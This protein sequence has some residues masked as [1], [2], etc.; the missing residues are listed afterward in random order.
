VSDA[1]RRSGAGHVRVA[2]AAGPRDGALLDVLVVT[3]DDLGRQEIIEAPR[4]G[5]ASDG[6]GLQLL[7]T[8]ARVP[9][10]DAP[11]THAIELP[12][13]DLSAW[14]ALGLAVPDDYLRCR[15]VRAALASMVTPHG[16]SVT[17]LHDWDGD[18]LHGLELRRAEPG[19]G[20]ERVVRAARATVTPAGPEL[21]LEEGTITTRGEERPFYGGSFRVALPGADFG[22]FLAA[23][24]P[25]AR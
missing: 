25:L 9:G 20:T 23:V 10:G 11:R 5:L 7:C 12:A 4:A 2:E 18:T 24:G 3:V 17:E 15:A 8:D 16:W 14:E 22:A 21:V 19:D 1:L 6:R 13:P